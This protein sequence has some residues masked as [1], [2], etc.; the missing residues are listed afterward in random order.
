MDPT[1]KL[2]IVRLMYYKLMKL[3]AERRFDYAGYKKLT[4]DQ[5]IN[6]VRILWQMEY[7]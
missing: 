2:Q 7:Y 1:S 6:Y 3:S 5:I 4:N